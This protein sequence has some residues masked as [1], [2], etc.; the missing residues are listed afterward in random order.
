MTDHQH[1]DELAAGY[2]LHGLVARGGGGVRR[3]P[4][5][6]PECAASLAD[7]ELVAAQLGTI[8]HFQDTDDAPTWE[9]MR[10]SIVGPRRRGA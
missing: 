9:S 3:P 4:R 10:D 1:W 8:S 6:C 2:A 5:T 7:H